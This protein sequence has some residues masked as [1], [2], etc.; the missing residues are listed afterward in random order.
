MNDRIADSVS[1]QVLLGAD[2]YRVFATRSREERSIYKII[3]SRFLADLK[4][5]PTA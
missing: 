2:E 3:Y 5:Q 4:I 1:Q